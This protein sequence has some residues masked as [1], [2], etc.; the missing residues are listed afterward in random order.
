MTKKS[1]QYNTDDN[2]R[3]RTQDGKCWSFVERGTCKSVKSH[4][5]N[6]YL[7]NNPN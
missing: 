3:E 7:Q 1:T 4:I 6:D 2:K 5:T